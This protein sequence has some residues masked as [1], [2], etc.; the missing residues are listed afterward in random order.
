MT[1]NL[2]VVSL[3]LLAGSA[4][5]G[6]PKQSKAPVPRPWDV[7]WTIA[8]DGKPIGPKPAETP[9]LRALGRALYR[10]QCVMCH[11]ENGDGKGALAAKLNPA[12]TDF[13]R[14]VFKVRSTPPGSLPTD[15]DLFRTL[16]RGLHGTAMQPWR[17]FAERERWALVTAIKHFSPRFE[18]EHPPKSIPVPIAPRELEPLRDA[19]ATLYVRMGCGACHGETGAGDGPAAALLAQDPTR[20]VQIRNFTRG[21]FL[22]GAEMEDLYLTLRVGV[23]GT[24]M[25]AYKDLSDDEIWALAAYVRLMIRER[26]LEGFPPARNPEM[27]LVGGGR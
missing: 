7:I 16:T 15:R 27:G 18:Q 26:P 8:P 19:G 2:V 23:E 3:L 4:V 21:R 9:R 1:K 11:G 22:R 6:E 24:P 20:K 13:T 10:G 14:G 12:P 5:A 17:Q 25:A